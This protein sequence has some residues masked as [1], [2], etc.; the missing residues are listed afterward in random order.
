MKVDF[1][2]R[3]KGRTSTMNKREG[4]IGIIKS[5]GT[6]IEKMPA[7]YT[8][9]SYIS[10]QNAYNYS[11][12]EKHSQ[13]SNDVT[14][15]SKDPVGHY[16]HQNIQQKQKIITCLSIETWNQYVQTMYRSQFVPDKEMYQFPLSKTGSVNLNDYELIAIPKSVLQYGIRVEHPDGDQPKSTVLPNISRQYYSKSQSL[17]LQQDRPMVKSEILNQ[18]SYAKQKEKRSLLIAGMNSIK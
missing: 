12:I 17:D 18:G 13:P 9:S 1:L 15:T 16:Q 8:F 4:V 2:T 6:P 7:S 14:P 5:N 3:F 10:N 11:D